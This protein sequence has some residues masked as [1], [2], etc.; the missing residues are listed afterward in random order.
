[1]NSIR[2]I[3]I[4][5]NAVLLSGLNAQTRH[6]FDPPLE[7]STDRI[8]IPDHSVYGFPWFGSESA[9][10]AKFGPPDGYIMVSPTERIY[11]YG[12]THAFT[13]DHDELRE[14]HINLFSLVRLVPD[15][16]IRSNP[17]MD[18]ED[19][20]LHPKIRPK[21]SKEDVEAALNRR[22]EMKYQNATYITENSIVT[23]TFFEFSGN[24]PSLKLTE[25]HVKRHQR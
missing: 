16:R 15:A 5:L 6:P 25:I 17:K 9:F 4:A 7:T 22:L 10:V 20:E 13:F 1:M 21:M 24:I 19:W 2:I 12:T 8:I 14:V 18:A 3:L 11:Y 23:L